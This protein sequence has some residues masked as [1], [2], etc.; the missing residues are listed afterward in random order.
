MY[1]YTS[2]YM[3]IC[4]CVLSLSLVRSQVLSNRV[5]GWVCRWVGGRWLDWKMGGWEREEEE[6][7]KKTIDIG[8]YKEKKSL[9][10]ATHCN[11]L[12]HPATHC[13]TLL[14]TAT[15][16]RALYHTAIH[17]YTLLHPATHCNTLLHTATHCNTLQHTATHC[18]TLLHTATT[19]NILETARN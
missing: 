15:H 11:T 18:Y 10:I 6:K 19:C 17:C 9:K 16:C 2:I 12:Q 14:H 1:V 8:L 5:G 4:A 7:G 13:N 3:Y